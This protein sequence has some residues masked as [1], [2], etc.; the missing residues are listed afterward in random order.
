[1]GRRP[2]YADAARDT[3]RAL[4]SR[5]LGLVYGGAHV[6]LMG[7][8]ADTVLSLGGEVYGVMPRSMVER[9]IAHRGLTQLDI[10]E[11]MHERKARMAALS[12][13]FLVLPGAFG[14]L[15]EMFEILTWAQLRIHSKP[16]AM[17]NLD[18]FYDALLE[19]LDR[20]VAEGFLKQS[21]RD[22][23]LVGSDVG[24]LL[25]RMHGYS[26]RIDEKW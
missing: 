6:G 18:G 13:G 20:S 24:A 12:D 15:D 16:V 7:I 2:I 19:F 3:A 22:L 25:D 21:N 23:F 9:E 8:L 14:T 11:T 4:A 1:M 17:L 26:P 5:G 10:V